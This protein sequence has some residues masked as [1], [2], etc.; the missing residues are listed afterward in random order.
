M[1]SSTFDAI[2]SNTNNI[3]AI[4][5]GAVA[6]TGLPASPTQ[7]GLTTAWENET[8]LTSLMNRA[9]IYDVTNSKVWTYYTNDNT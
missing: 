5:S 7:A 2:A 3:N 8:G 9:G 4:L 6:I 1:N